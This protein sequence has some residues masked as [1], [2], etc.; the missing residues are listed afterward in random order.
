MEQKVEKNKYLSS[1]SSLS[2]QERQEALIFLKT[3]K[4]TQKKE[5]QTQ[6]EKS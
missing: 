2:P 4:F 3:I 5:A 6:K 1:T